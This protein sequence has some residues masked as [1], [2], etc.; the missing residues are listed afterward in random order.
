MTVTNV[1]VAVA[2]LSSA[3]SLWSS[4]LVPLWVPRP[5]QILSLA[6]LAIWI[7]IRMFKLPSFLLQ[8][9]LRIGFQAASGLWGKESS[10]SLSHILTCVCSSKTPNLECV[11][12]CNPQ[13]GWEMLG[14]GL[15]TQGLI[16]C[17]F[18]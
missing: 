2:E 15:L 7:L 9:R 5:A 10:G 8:L 17:Y 3:R 12:V 1:P 4:G 18:V 16:C 6:L 13:D 11:P 14:S